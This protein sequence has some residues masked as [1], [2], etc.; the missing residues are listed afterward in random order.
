MGKTMKKILISAFVVLAATGVLFSQQAPPA[1]KSAAP[2]A[3]QKKEVAPPVAMPKVD[4]DYVIGIEDVLAIAVWKDA[5]SSVPQAVVTP[6]GMIRLPLINEVKADGLTVSQLRDLLT[7]KYSRFLKDPT[8][9]VIPLKIES[10]KVHIIG[11]VSKP[12][13]YPLT[14]PMTV[15]ELI[16]RAGGLTELAKTKSIKI[17][18]KKDGRILNFNYKDV[19]GGKNLKQNVFL[20]NGDN[21][22]IPG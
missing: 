18:R 17:M 4:E 22:M 1:T 3:A 20:E 10:K 16:A 8:V 9:A 13:I 21:V 5:D 6:D 7:E 15:L 2:A 19:I 11:Q 12:G 14:A